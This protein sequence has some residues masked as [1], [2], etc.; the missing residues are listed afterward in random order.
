M[1]SSILIVFQSCLPQGGRTAFECQLRHTT[2]GLEACTTTPYFVPHGPQR[3]AETAVGIAV[4]TK[5]RSPRREG[6]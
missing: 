6:G 2:S 3:P 1:T 4:G 5:L